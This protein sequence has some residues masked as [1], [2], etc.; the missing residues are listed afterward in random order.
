VIAKA[1]P[2]T[3]TTAAQ[4]PATTSDVRRRGRGPGPGRGPLSAVVGEIGGAEPNE[5]GGGDG[6][7]DGVGV[8]GRIA[9]AVG[10]NT[11]WTPELRMPAAAS[12]SMRSWSASA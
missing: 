6:V 10:W 3:S 4:A 7:P 5:R 2:P 8:A 11:G 9:V 12:R 1:P